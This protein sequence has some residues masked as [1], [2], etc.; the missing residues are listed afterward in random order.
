MNHDHHVAYFDVIY[1]I[2]S[3]ECRFHNTMTG[4]LAIQ[5]DGTIF[6][7]PDWNDFMVRTLTLWVNQA[8][9]IIEHGTP[10][11]FSFM[12]GPPEFTVARKSSM[13]AEIICFE[14]HGFRGKAP[15]AFI[16][17]AQFGAAIHAAA[18]KAENWARRNQCESA[19]VHALTDGMHALQ[20]ELTIMERGRRH[21]TR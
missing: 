21:L 15:S 3:M 12:D 11:L 6:P 14:A 8:R 13:V 5:L 17:L 19:H 20:D 9:I 18:R 16:E 7:D 10:E 2:E 4:I 1:D